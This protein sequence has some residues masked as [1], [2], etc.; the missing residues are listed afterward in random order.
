[1]VRG[2]HPTP[3]QVQKAGASLPIPE[4]WRSEFASHRNAEIRQ[5]RARTP[6]RLWEHA[7]SISV[8][9]LPQ[10][11]VPGRSVAPA[12][13]RIDRAM[14][15]TSLL[16]RAAPGNRFGAAREIAN[17][18]T[19]G[20]GPERAGELADDAQRLIV[21]LDARFDPADVGLLGGDTPSRLL[22]DGRAADQ[23]RSG[24]RRRVE[25]RS[26][27]LSSIG[28]VRP[29][30]AA[31]DSSLEVDPGQ[32]ATALFSCGAA[33]LVSPASGLPAPNHGVQSVRKSIGGSPVEVMA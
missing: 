31:K 1:M 19:V 9:A 2:T 7:E 29:G 20:V 15:S 21:F 5:P 18:L 17:A 25:P 33:G 13:R 24:N 8:A 27:S 6:V 11:C 23:K 28:I 3:S 4:R 22:G 30:L 14:Q 32:S 16:R 10:R 26:A 12:D